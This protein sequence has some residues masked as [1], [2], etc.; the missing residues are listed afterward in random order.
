MVKVELVVAV[1]FRP[2]VDAF[3]RVADQLPHLLR[4]GFGN[5]FPQPQEH[6]ERFFDDLIG[7]R[8][9]GVLGGVSVIE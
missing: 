3:H 7:S 2:N 9:F 8:G 1:P 4:I 6:A 5:G